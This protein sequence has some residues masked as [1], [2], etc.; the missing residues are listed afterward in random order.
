MSL[1]ASTGT[2]A[3]TRLGAT[4][5]ERAGARAGVTAGARV[6][7]CITIIQTSRWVYLKRTLLHRCI[8]IFKFF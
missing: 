1:G 6:R 2:R 4:A 8:V 5:G 3:E 7:M